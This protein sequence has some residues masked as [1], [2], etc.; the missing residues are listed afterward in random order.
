M[1]LLWPKSG[2]RYLTGENKMEWM[3]EGKKITAEKDSGVSWFD[4]TG[5]ATQN[6]P[7]YFSFTI[8]FLLLTFALFYSSAGS[9]Q[10]MEETVDVFQV[11]DID[12]V[13]MPKRMSKREI[14]I[15]SE[16]ETPVSEQVERAEGLSDAEDAVDLAFYPD[17]VPPRPQGKL[18]K[19][20][21]EEGR[22]KEIEA[23]VFVS[24]VIGQEG[25]V[26]SVN[27]LST[28]LSKPLP[29]EV[30]ETMKK[31]FAIAA[32]KIM[33]SARFSPPIIDGKKVSIIMEMP[34]KFELN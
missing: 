8:S 10:R 33:Q 20:Y 25:N 24:L 15:S 18:Q 3:K 19:I 29:D 9:I 16:A 5:Q 28:R 1:L 30:T 22:Q 14:A 6:H 26:L 12:K 23:I 34:L 32:V 2:G 11:L 27:V 31:K 21:P 7:F 17:V 13:L 4:K